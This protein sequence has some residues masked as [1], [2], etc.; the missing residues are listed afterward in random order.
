MHGGP[1]RWPT[2]QALE[3]K[4]QFVCPWSSC[5]CPG[6][7]PVAGVASGL[8]FGSL[9]C[10]SYSGA[11]GPVLMWKRE[12]ARRRELLLLSQASENNTLYAFG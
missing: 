11:V 8:C 10:L 9:E 1:D 7:P 2:H 3:D 5:T 6:A 4:V 12:S